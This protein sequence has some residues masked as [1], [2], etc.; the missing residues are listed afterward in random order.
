M[1]LK[2]L[3]A[4]DVCRDAKRAILRGCK[5]GDRYYHVV[6]DDYED[7]EP[8]YTYNQLCAMGRVP[9]Y[10]WGRMWEADHYPDG[11]RICL[12]RRL[13]EA[14]D[15]CRE[16]GG[17]ILEVWLRPGEAYAPIEWESYWPSAFTTR[18][19]PIPY[20]QIVPIGQPQRAAGVGSTPG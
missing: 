3:V 13:T 11:D 12:Q 15:F 5:Y 17:R 7:G 10:K 8:L 20:Q 6:A 2:R 4:C 16:Y 18:N 9:R 19:T 14:E 1:V